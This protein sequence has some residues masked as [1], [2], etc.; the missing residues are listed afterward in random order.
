MSLGSAMYIGVAG[1][2]S[3][4]QGLS[5]IA[6]NVANADTTAYKSNKVLFGDMVSD[7]MISTQSRDTDRTGTGARVMGVSTDHNLGTLESTTKWSDLAISGQGF[8]AVTLMDDDGNL[9]TPDQTYYTRDG[10]FHVEKNGYLVNYQG[11]AVLNEDGEPI[12]VDDPLNPVFGSYTVDSDG[13][14]YGSPVNV[15]TFDTT[16]DFNANDGTGNPAEI[17]FTVNVPDD[18]AGTKVF[19]TVTANVW[20]ANGNLAA[21]IDL[22]SAHAEIAAGSF[23]GQT[24]YTGIDLTGFLVDSTSP[25]Y[26]GP[27]TV[28]LQTDISI[29]FA[30]PNGQ[31]AVTTFPNPDGLIRQGGNLYATGPTSGDPTPGTANDGTRGSIMNLTLE[32]SNVDLASQMVDMIIYQADYNANSK[33]ITTAS[34]LIDVAISMVR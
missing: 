21:S 34:K 19:D 18:G 12:R 13:Q 8:F 27:Y 11:Y 7:F 6:D 10:S 20:D 16:T 1:L 30:V 9:V 22:T 17:T 4:S 15:L 2:N 31:V 24:T 32:G 3:F 23:T 5:V 26:A 28:T 14:I 25:T 29:P 33:T